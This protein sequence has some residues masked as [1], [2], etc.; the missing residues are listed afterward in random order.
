M[1]F[2]EPISRV[3]ELNGQPV[4]KNHKLTKVDFA[5]GDKVVVRFNNKD[6]RGV[7]DFSWDE[8]TLAECADS[9]PVSESP[10]EPECT[11]APTPTTTEAQARKRHRSQDVGSGQRSTLT[12]LQRRRKTVSNI[13]KLPG[14]VP[15]RK[16]Q[17]TPGTYIHAAV[18][19]CAELYCLNYH[20][21]LMHYCCA[22][23]HV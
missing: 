21:P 12:K 13:E 23:F 8:E 11:S 6:V 20:E 22:S 4:P 18:H 5:S 7:V 9:P 19:A 2:M 3:R 1:Y 10:D 14:G 17:R 15:A 16:K